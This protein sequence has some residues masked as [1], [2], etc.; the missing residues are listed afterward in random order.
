M[1]EQLT[2][3][4]ERVDDSPVLLADNG[5]CRSWIRWACSWPPNLRQ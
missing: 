4:T 2:V 5:C 1:E 3:T